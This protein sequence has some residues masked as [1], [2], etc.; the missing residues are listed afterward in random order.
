MRAAAARLL[1][2]IETSP[3]AKRARERADAVLHYDSPGRRCVRGAQVPS[4]RQG[5]RRPGRCRRRPPLRGSGPTTASSK[6]RRQAPASARSGC[7]RSCRWSRPPTGSSG[8]AQLPSRWC[9]AASQDGVGEHRARGW[10]DAAV[11]FGARGWANQLWAARVAREEPGPLAALA[12]TIFPLMDAAE[13][14]E[15][16]ATILD[17]GS[18][19]TWNGILAAAPRPWSRALADAFSE[20]AH[21]RVRQCA[22]RLAGSVCLA[23]QP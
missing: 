7:G 2:R 22:A 23:Y 11:R 9:I 3:L 14:H 21:A 12:A 18:P 16:A 8:S 19:Q 4:R 20:G 13:V 1:A 15:T 6:S 10:T 5:S 17:G